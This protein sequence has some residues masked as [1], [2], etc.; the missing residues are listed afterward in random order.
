MPAVSG[1]VYTGIG[2]PCDATE[3]AAV[4]RPLHRVSC[5]GSS[6]ARG[7]FAEGSQVTVGIWVFFVLKVSYA[8]RGT[9]M[10]VCRN[11]TVF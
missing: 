6:S 9:S 1:A 8:K 2:P 5:L 11:R 3:G 7:D 4:S 10:R